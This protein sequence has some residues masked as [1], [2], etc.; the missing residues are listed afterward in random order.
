MLRTATTAFSSLV[1]V[2]G[3]AACGSSSGASGDT[4]PKKGDQTANPCGGN[5]CGDGHA[6]N[7]CAK[8]VAG[9]VDC[10][11]WPQW[12]KVNTKR[13]VSKGHGKKWSDV[14]V[15]PDHAD[16]Y[17]KLAAGATFPE[18]MRVVK[19]HYAAEGDEKPNSI[20]VMGKMKK[21]YDAEHKDWYYG[22]YN[23]AGTKAIKAGK[24]GMCISCHANSEDQD[25]LG[26]LPEG[27]VAE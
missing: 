12:V 14:Y 5:P 4:T 20:M 16:A 19:A 25:Y 11:E 9:A 7:P 27:L 21:G 26:G 2:L 8:G 15:T 23:A 3:L 22:I 18:G 10:S 24:I 6:F 1:I 13:F 17:K